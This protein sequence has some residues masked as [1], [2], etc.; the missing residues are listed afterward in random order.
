MRN[1]RDFTR[2]RGFLSSVELRGGCTLWNRHDRP[3]HWLV[4]L[5]F[6]LDGGFAM[7]ATDPARAAQTGREI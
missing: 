6:E 1:T 2:E 4:E 7:S 5:H 3:N